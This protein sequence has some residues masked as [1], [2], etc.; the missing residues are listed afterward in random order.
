MKTFVG[1]PT[2]VNHFKDIIDYRT[3]RFYRERLEN[4]NV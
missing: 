3:T 1:N 2:F 4:L